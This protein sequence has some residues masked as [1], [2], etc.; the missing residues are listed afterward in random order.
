MKPISKILAYLGISITS[1]FIFAITWVIV[2]TL[3]L[4]KA[5][6]AHGQMPFQDPLVFPIMSICAAVSGLIA[7]P[8][9]TRLGWAASP[10]KVA[11]RAG[12]VTVVFIIVATPFSAGIGWFGSYAAL[13]I[14]LIACSLGMK[15][16]GQPSPSPYSSPAAGS[17]SG[18]A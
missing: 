14:A 16:S 11:R 1:A 15:R 4:P 7:W 9:Y 10:V 2:M 6:L 5:D 8:F 18:E 17:E 12:L 3:T 13:L